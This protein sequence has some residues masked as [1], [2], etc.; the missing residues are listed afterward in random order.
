MAAVRFGLDAT[1]TF[2]VA[3]SRRDCHSKFQSR[4]RSELPGAAGADF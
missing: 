1:V 4:N 2:I 3:S